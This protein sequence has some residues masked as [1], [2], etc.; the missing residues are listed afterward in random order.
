MAFD[1]YLFIHDR[2]GDRVIPKDSTPVSPPAASLIRREDIVAG[3]GDMI[4]TYRDQ[5][6]KTLEGVAYPAGDQVETGR[7]LSSAD[8]IAER[9]KTTVVFLVALVVV[10]SIAIAGA[11]MVAAPEDTRLP[12]WLLGTGLAAGGAVAWLYKREQALTPEALERDRQNN[13]WDI[14]RRDAKTRRILAEG[15]VAVWKSFADADVETRRA[16]L[17]Q[18]DL[19]SLRIEAE[20]EERRYRR[21]Q[22]IEETVAPTV[23]GPSR[24]SEETV[25]TAVSTEETVGRPL[26]IVGETVTQLP[27]ITD[28]VFVKVAEVVAGLYDQVNPD[29]PLI[30]VA[31]PWSARS[32]AMSPAAK[33]LVVSKLASLSPPLIESRNGR[34]YLNV[35]SYQGP[36]KALRTLAA[37]WRD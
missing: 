24:P 13:D 30:T 7:Y 19:D 14:Q 23:W 32:T 22:A 9:R 3:F 4:A 27:A 37:A 11:V 29:N 5:Q 6:R 2:Q 26:A 28:P 1:D 8:E 21:R 31:L 20:L 18:V 10:V 35:A 17:R 12:L 33:D 36:K 25:E 34:Y 15:Q 16:Q